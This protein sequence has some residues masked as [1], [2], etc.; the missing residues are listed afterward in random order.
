MVAQ[1]RQ[2]LNLAGQAGGAC[3]HRRSAC[4]QSSLTCIFDLDLTHMQEARAHYLN[5]Q[6][7]PTGFASA[8]KSC[9]TSRQWSK[10]RNT[11]IVAGDCCLCWKVV[12]HTDLES[13]KALCKKKCR[14]QYQQQRKEQPSRDDVNV[15]GTA[16]AAL[17]TRH[18]SLKVA[19]AIHC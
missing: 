14:E 1:Q 12:A 3:L 15:A 2:Q 4:K 17:G 13:I 8:L 9:C 6:I 11:Q 19:M 5:G 16:M 18:H 10:A 7:T